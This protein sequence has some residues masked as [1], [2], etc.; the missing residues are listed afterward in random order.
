MKKSLKLSTKLIIGFGVIFVLTLLI[1]VSSFNGLT[2][3][4]DGFIEYKDLSFETN[5]DGRIQANMLEA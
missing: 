3:S 2:S 4:I 1:S 5:L